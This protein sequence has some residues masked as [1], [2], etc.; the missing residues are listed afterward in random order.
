LEYV[1][2]GLSELPDPTT[3][4]WQ[5][6]VDTLKISSERVELPVPIRRLAARLLK[7]SRE[8]EFIRT[9]VQKQKG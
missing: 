6:I 7:N 9:I 3:S 5:R 8:G 2:K 1:I 4:I